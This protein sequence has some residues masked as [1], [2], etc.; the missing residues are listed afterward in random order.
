MAGTV[1]DPNP[2][3]A[4]VVHAGARARIVVDVVGAVVRPGV[5]EFPASSRVVDAVDAAGG[6]TADADRIRLNLAEPLTDGSRVWVPAVGE[7]SAPEL[8]PVVT[9]SGSGTAAGGGRGGGS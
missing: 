9:A 8:V 5:H 6:F 1:L 2:G 3:P 7:S 4:L